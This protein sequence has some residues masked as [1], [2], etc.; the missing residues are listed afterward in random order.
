LLSEEEGASTTLH[1][2]KTPALAT[3]SGLYYV[4]SQATKPFP[5]TQ[6]PE[7]A[8][9]LWTHSKRWVAGARLFLRDQVSK[10]QPRATNRLCTTCYRVSAFVSRPYGTTGRSRPKAAC[11]KRPKASR[12]YLALV[13]GDGRT[14]KPAAIQ[15]GE[16][17]QLR[18][19]CNLLGKLVPLIIQIMLDN[20]DTLWGDANYP[21]VG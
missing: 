18:G 3:V 14:L 15:I 4:D 10:A 17:S 13:D 1:C 9:W 5:T 2:A 6:S 16:A 19:C 11:R 12:F 7:L 21:V 8:N 20:P